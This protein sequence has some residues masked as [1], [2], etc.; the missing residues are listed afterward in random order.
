[1]CDLG[2]TSAVART[3]QR[4]AAPDAPFCVEAGRHHNMFF[5]CPNARSALSA[6]RG[7]H[8]YA[9]VRR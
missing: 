8:R 3:A 9:P 5:S 6:E 7:C 1:M 4:A 2:L